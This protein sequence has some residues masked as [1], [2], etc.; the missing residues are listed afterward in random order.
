MLRQKQKFKNSILT[1]ADCCL[2]S[3]KSYYLHPMGEWNLKGIRLP[4]AG[5]AGAK[6]QR[7]ET[8]MQ[9]RGGGFRC[10]SSSKHACKTLMVLAA[11]VPLTTYILKAFSQS[12][13]KREK[14]LNSGEQTAVNDV[15]YLQR[16]DCT[17]AK[18]SMPRGRRFTLR[19]NLQT[20]VSGVRSG[21]PAILFPDGG[22]QLN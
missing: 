20:M 19:W 4:T 9:H 12:E 5:G 22:L 1:S 18:T 14:V 2:R 11:V 10:S 8:R 13:R 21:L 16:A 17:L 7:A 15:L 6:P 3:R